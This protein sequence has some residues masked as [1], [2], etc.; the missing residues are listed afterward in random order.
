VT[1]FSVYSDMTTDDGGWTLVMYMDDYVSATTFA[2]ASSYRHEY[3]ASQSGDCK[4]SDAE[5]NAILDYGTG[6]TDRF[7]FH[8]QTYDDYAYFNTTS[9]WAYNNTSGD[10]WYAPTDSYLSTHVSASRHYCMY[11]AGY[12]GTLG[13]HS[14]AEYYFA[15]D[16]S[17]TAC[18]RGGDY[19]VGSNFNI[20]PFV[21]WAK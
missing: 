13:S 1:P 10:D 9:D 8:A 14:S 6:T 16:P 12:Y 11:G 20:G 15:R 2:T 7:R 4:F 18:L 21:W 19:N 17:N 5:I 3:C